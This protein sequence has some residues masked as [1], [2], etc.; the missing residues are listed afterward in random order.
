MINIFLGSIVI[1]FI[2]MLFGFVF[3]LILKKN[4]IVDVMWGIGF[5]V[6]SLYSLFFFSDFSVTQ[7]LV[8]FLVII[9]GSRLSIHIFTRNFKKPEDPRYQKWRK[10]WG[11]HV[12]IR[13][14]FQIFMLQGIL[15]LLIVSPIL[16]IN[17]SKQDNSLFFW[18][19]ILIWFFGYFFETVGDYQLRQF[20]KKPENKGK[21]MTFGLWKYT[22]HP[23]YFGESL[24]WWGFWLIS[25]TTPYG[26]YLVFSPLIITFL[27]LRVSG[28]PLLE[29]KYKGRPDWEDYKKSTSAFIPWFPKKA[30]L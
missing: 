25:L 3:S 20:I 5:I 7:L 1:I 12:A 17:S 29:E 13:S 16:F 11:K 23:N 8:T 14:F 15:L 9:W 26:L 6:L 4:S 19:G 2:Y 10:E 21:L 30:G 24:I 27:L 22:R 28:I 18:L